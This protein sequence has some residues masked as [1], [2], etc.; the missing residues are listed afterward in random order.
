MECSDA[1]ALEP[2]ELLRIPISQDQV[3][4]YTT[5][6][7][8]KKFESDPSTVYCPRKK[9]EGIA[10]TEIA[11]E[12]H[13]AMR[14]G[15]FHIPRSQRLAICC[16]CAFAFCVCC[17]A[18]WHGTLVWCTDRLA[19][20]LSAEEK[21]SEAY[22]K[23]HSTRCPFCNSATQKNRGCNH[24]ICGTCQQSFCYLCSAKLEARDPYRHFNSES[25]VGGCKG[26]LWERDEDHGE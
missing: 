23:A 1:P 10:R 18:S 2:S 9:C 25:A 5:L 3:S 17:K 7:L 19:A 21:A 4:R 20:E 22:M 15:T 12:Y 6:Q 11:K 24:M 26:R 16:S 14:T 13:D 8:K